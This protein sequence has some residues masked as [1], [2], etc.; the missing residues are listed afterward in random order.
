[1]RV[2]DVEQQQK[3]KL[4]YVVALDSRKSIFFSQQPTKNMWTQRRRRRGRG[5]TRGGMHEGC[6]F[7]VLTA[8]KRKY[9]KKI[10]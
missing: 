8:M 6:S 7:V 9:D 1:M 3:C 4:K 10:K 5:S 2:S